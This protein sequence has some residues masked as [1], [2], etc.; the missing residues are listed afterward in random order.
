M[1]FTSGQIQQNKSKS[2]LSIHVVSRSKM[3]RAMK[4]NLLKKERGSCTSKGLGGWWLS[5]F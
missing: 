1:R 4:P 3:M 5:L 2:A